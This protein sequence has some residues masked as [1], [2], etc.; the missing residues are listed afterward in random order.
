MIRISRVNM[1]FVIG[2]ALLAA[3]CSGSSSS[4]T[5]PADAA[6]ESGR[7][8]VAVSVEAGVAGG[9]PGERRG[10]R[11]ARAEVLGRREVRGLGHGRRRCTSPSGCRCARAHRLARLDTTRDRGG[12]RGAEGGARPRRASAETRAK[13]EYE[14]APAAQAVRPD[15]AAGLR[16]REVGA[17]KR[18]RRRRPRPQAQVRTAEAR[19][20][21]STHRGADGR[22]RRVPRRQRRRPRR[23]H[24]RRR[25]RCSASSTTGCST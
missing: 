2:A 13:R 16:R 10:R 23:E 21:K 19:L 18:P 15:H 3:S 4:G 25:V 24:G 1:S 20:A 7:P 8:P 9:L 12:H 5:P 11:V 14:R 22:R 17:S 6:K